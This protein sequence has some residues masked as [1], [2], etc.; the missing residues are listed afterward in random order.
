MILKHLNFNCIVDVKRRIYTLDDDAWSLKGRFAVA[1]DE[2][3]DISWMKTANGEH[4]AHLLAV[5]QNPSIM[6][7]FN[8][9][10]ELF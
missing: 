1:E 10:I 8:I 4:V 7:P 3:E 9:Y 5:S 2:D 6:Y